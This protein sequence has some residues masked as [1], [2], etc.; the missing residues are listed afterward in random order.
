MVAALWLPTFPR[1]SLLHIDGQ[2]HIKLHTLREFAS[3][4]ARAVHGD[5]GCVLVVGPPPLELP[6]SPIVSF[7]VSTAS[8]ALSL[9][10]VAVSLTAS[11]VP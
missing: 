5:N 11:M 8:C 2:H 9:T 4:S 1:G 10:L 6:L 7:T 3:A